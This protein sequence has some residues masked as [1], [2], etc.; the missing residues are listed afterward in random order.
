MRHVAE[1]RPRSAASTR[2]SDASGSSTSASAKVARLRHQPA[3]FQPRHVEQAGQQVGGRIQRAAD[4][5]ARD[6]RCAALGELLRQ[7]IGEQVRGVQRLQ[8][9]VA[10]RGEE[11]ALGVVGA[12]GLA[13]GGLQLAR[14]A[15]P[16]A[17]PASRWPAAASASA[18]R[19][20]VTSVKVATKPPPGI[21][22]PRIST[23]LPSGNTRS[24]RCGGAGAHVREAPLQR[25]LGDRRWA[26][27]AAAPSAARSAIGVPTCSS[28]R[29]IAEQL[30]IAAVPRHQPQLRID[31]ADALAHVL[32]RRF[33]HALVEAQVLRG[34]ADDRRD[35]V[36]VR[37][38]SRRAASSSTR[39]D[40]EPSTAA[41]SRSTCASVCAGTAPVAGRL[42][43]QLRRRVRAAGSANRHRAGSAHRGRAARAAAPR[44]ATARP[45]PWPRCPTNRLAPTARPE[46][47][48][49]GQPEQPVRRQPVPAERPVL[50]PRR[51][52]AAH[53]SAIGSSSTQHHTANP[54][55]DAGHR[56]ARRRLRPP[57][58][59]APAPAPAWPARRTTPRRRRPAPRCR[60]SRGCTPT[61]AA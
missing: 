25:A 35:G 1:R 16:R 28:V 58:R 39:A 26:A 24:D 60:R 41:S 61:P 44:G 49:A 37:R 42:V 56:R 30:G 34:L 57:H 7:R 32:Q 38:P 52:D 19:N 48:P 43:Q 9:V 27:S 2:N 53:S 3:G 13:L 40:A 11:A 33:E 17:A 23:M 46:A 55:S 51:R 8:Q 20:A 10:D 21:G 47:A 22:L 18:R 31:H 50:Q 14:C 12:L 59:E 29:G 5:R 36:Q 54:A 15:R 6:S 4:L 45:A